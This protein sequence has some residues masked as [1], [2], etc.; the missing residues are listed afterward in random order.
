MIL[1]YG[2]PQL[3]IANRVQ[4]TTATLANRFQCL[5]VAPQYRLNRYGVDTLAAGVAFSDDG[6]TLAYRYLDTNGTEAALP[7]TDVVDLDFA[8]LYAEKLE[9]VLASY[10]TGAANPIK[11]FSLA[12]PSVLKISGAAFKGTNL[13]TPFESRDVAVGDIVYVNDGVSGQRKRKVV[14]FRGVAIAASYGANADKDDTNAGNSTY[15]PVT[16]SVD[17]TGNQVTDAAPSGMTIA[18]TNA[19]SFNGLTRGSRFGTKYGEQFT[20]TVAVGGAPGTATVNI[21]STSGLWAASGVATTADPGTTQLETATVASGAT[22]TANVVVTVT[23]AGIAG[24]PLVTNVAVASGDTAAQVATKIRAALGGVGAITSVYT[25]GGT[26]VSVTLTR[27][28]AATNDGTLNIGINGTTNTTG[29]TDAPTSANTRAGVAVDPDIYNIASAE[30]AGTGAQIDCN[31]TPLSSGDVFQYEVYGAYT[32][33]GN[34][35]LDVSDAGSGYTGAKDTTYLVEV[36][37]GTTGGSFTGGTLRITDTAG[38]DEPQD[39]NVTDNTYFNVGSHGLRMRLPYSAMAAQNGLRKGDVYFVFAKAASA[40]TTSFDKLVLDGP[41]SDTTLFTDITTALTVEFR[42]AFTGQIAKD[43]SADED[44]W[45]ATTGGIVVGSGLSLLV[46]ARSDGNKWCPFADTVGK[47]FPSFRS[48][49]PPVFQEDVLVLTASDIDGGAVGPVDLD[50]DAGFAC[51]AAIGGSQGRPI[52]FLRVAGITAT[53]FSNA[54]KKVEATDAWYSLGIMTEDDAVMTAAKN[55]AAAMS[56]PDVKNFRKIYVGTDSPGSYNVVKATS[57]STLVTATV[58]Q[59]NSENILVTLVNGADEID[60]T[61][62]GLADGDRVLLPVGGM[63]FELLNVISATELVLKSGPDAPISPAVPLEIW[64]ADTVASQKSFLQ[65]RAESLGFELVVNVWSES[66][67]R[68]ING[69][70][71]FIPARFL[72]AEVAGIRSALMPQQGLTRTEVTS[73]TA[74]PAMYIKYSQTDLDDIAKFGN[75]VIT[76]NSVGGTVFIRHQ[77]TTETDKGSLYYED[78]AHAIIHYIDFRT[79]DICDPFI[80]KKN[81][82]ASVVAKVQRQL[83]AMLRENSLSDVKQLS[84]DTDNS[85]DLGPMLVGYRN[86]LV[87]IDP[88]LKD[89]FQVSGILTIPLPLNNIDVVWTSEVTL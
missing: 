20:L 39:I 2:R 82:I 33:L 64:K 87:I 11:L 5:I 43:A 53:D 38:Y 4:Q 1:N 41:A 76:Q 6:Q 31:G 75:F 60:F 57:D 29:V 47:L 69:V 8:K 23:G 36:T 67:N 19:A 7:G 44:A 45:D 62:L 89:R 16:A 25:V 66:Q 46:D 77:L 68:F 80:G 74:C 3:T 79:K 70:P 18:V 12:E 71:T 51:S 24:S 84:D 26:G 65:Q 37:T 15:N 30:L 85:D 72:A 61:L 63:E 59:F 54:L 40:S 21:R 52:G 42:L 55:H 49:V 35:Q 78:N 73:V 48:L 10:S 56:Q 34:T 88:V 27:I 32:R 9:A 17:G 13:D 86:L 22:G 58:S 14:G 81:A 28:A 50:N 83:D